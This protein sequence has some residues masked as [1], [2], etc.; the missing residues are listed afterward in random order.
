MQPGVYTMKAE[1]AGFQT[2]TRTGL[3]LGVGQAL[4]LAYTLPV[5]TLADQITVSGAS[6]LIEVTQTTIGT[7]MSTQDISNLP[8]QG[9][10]C[11]R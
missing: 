4:T 3:R 9:A 1:L 8:T 7:N 10:R 5:G 2:Q 11:C 6:P